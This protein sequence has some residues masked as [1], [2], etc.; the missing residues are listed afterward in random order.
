MCAEFHLHISFGFKMVGCQ[1]LNIPQIVTFWTPMSK[2]TKSRPENHL[3]KFAFN[4]RFM[5]KY[6]DLKSFLVN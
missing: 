3:C 1:I 4:P 2:F 5:T 6:V